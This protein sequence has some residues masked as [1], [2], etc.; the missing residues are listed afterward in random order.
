RQEFFA[1]YI[2]KILELGLTIPDS[3]LHFD[4]EANAWRYTEPDWNELKMVVTGHGPRSQERL[5][6]RRH[7]YA[8][9]QWVRDAVMG[10]AELVA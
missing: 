8:D 4:T 7:A 6:L 10:E 1:K 5:D 2:P 9:T 3:E